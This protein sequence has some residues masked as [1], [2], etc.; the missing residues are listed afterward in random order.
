MCVI[1]AYAIRNSVTD[2]LI[3]LVFGVVGWI[4]ARYGFAA[5][6][7]V[8]GLILG[9]IAEQGF[10]QGRLIGGAKGDVLGEFFG[11]PISMAIIALSLVSL[12]YPMLAKRMKLKREGVGDAD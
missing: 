8:L 9:P 12:F 10:V 4:L 3:M 1:G 11:R 2:V 6:P 7:I 5:S